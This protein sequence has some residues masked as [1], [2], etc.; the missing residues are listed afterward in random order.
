MRNLL[1]CSTT[2]YNKKG[3]VK[4]PTS[5]KA[6]YNLKGF[7]KILTKVYKKTS[8]HIISAMMRESKA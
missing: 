1:K 3:V 4:L 5:E 8:T 6:I 2:T 7:W